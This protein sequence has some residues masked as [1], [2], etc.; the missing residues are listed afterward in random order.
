MNHNRYKQIMQDGYG[1]TEEEW[2]AGWHFC[3]EWDYL[4]IGPLMPQEMESCSCSK[5]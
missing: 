3:P 5:Q 4:L 2:E 1:L